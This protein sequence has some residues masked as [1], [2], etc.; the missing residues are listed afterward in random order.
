MTPEIA[1]EATCLPGSFHPDPA[2][3]IIVATARHWNCAL[4][5]QDQRIRSYPYV[6]LAP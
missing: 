5:T 2:D 6:V 4:V 1:V 3:R